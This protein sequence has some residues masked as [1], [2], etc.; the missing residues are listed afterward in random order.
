MPETFMLTSSTKA[1]CAP[2]AAA[3]ALIERLAKSP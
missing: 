1:K 2:P 3:M